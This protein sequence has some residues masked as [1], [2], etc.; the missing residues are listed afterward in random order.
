MRLNRFIGLAVCA[1]FAACGQEPASQSTDWVLTN[2]LIYTVDEDQPW[3]RL[4]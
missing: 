2:G 3:P 1:L 4:S